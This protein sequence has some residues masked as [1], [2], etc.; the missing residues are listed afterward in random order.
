MALPLVAMFW[1]PAWVLTIG[2]IINSMLRDAIPFIPFSLRVLY[3]RN[4]KIT[5]FA[6]R[7]YRTLTSQNLW[8]VMSQFLSS[9]SEYPTRNFSEIDFNDADKL[10]AEG[11]I[12]DVYKTRWQR[13][14]VFVKRLKE[15][16]RDNPLYLDALEKEFDIGVSLNHPALPTYLA[17]GRDH[18]VMEFVDG[19]TLKSLLESG[20][21]W[22]G[23]KKNFISLLKVLTEA[24]DYLH[25]HKI[26]H[27]DIKPD[28]VMLTAN[29]YNPVLIDFDKCY[30]DAFNDTSGHPEKFGLP[31]Q[32]AG[33]VQMDYRGLGKV[34]EAIVAKYPSLKNRKIRNFIEASSRSDVTAESLKEILD[35]KPKIGAPAILWLLLSLVIAGIMVFTFS[36]LTKE[37][38][39]ISENLPIADTV[40]GAT[41]PE[42]AESVLIP[43]LETGGYKVS[44]SSET[45]DNVRTQ[46]QLYAEAQKR[47]EVLDKIVAPYFNRLHTGLDNLTRLKNSTALSGEQ[48]LDSLR[49]FGDTEDEY[50]NEVVEILK[51]TFPGISEREFW[52][53]M[54]SSKQYTGYKRRSEPIQQEIGREIQRRLQPH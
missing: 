53:V 36:V 42:S 48:L 26:V 52:R 1:C 2:K 17:F 44:E 20:N 31:V 18:I 16:Y 25:C 50:I 19:I 21:P 13:R 9:V 47:A 24:V 37:K 6:F 43:A 27:C 12:C 49:A 54:A 5:K 51:E 10:E 7:S 23:Q 14:T 40:Y 3:L 4:Q 34:A 30:T 45:P 8:F 46:E 22:L 41:A 11:S 29:G 28:N 32:S 35:S 33:R 38:T 39:A 15:E